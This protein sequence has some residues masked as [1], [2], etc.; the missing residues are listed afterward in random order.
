MKRELSPASR[1]L[2]FALAVAI[3]AV[4]LALLFVLDPSP[5]HAHRARPAAPAPPAVV[6]GSPSPLSAA[7]P[8]PAPAAV[9]AGRRFLRLYARV[10]SQPLGSSAARELRSLSSL[11]LARTLL[12]Q[13]PLPAGGARSGAALVA[14]RPERLSS[15]GVL[16][17]AAVR[18]AGSLVRVR[19]LLQRD[20]KRW[21]VTALL[22]AP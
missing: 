17:H 20:K 19:C 16:L 8:P 14:V 2:L 4:A 10:Q 15:S 9:A 1:L 22:S 21:T 7:E 6:Y 5:H 3:A 13:P 11:A 12:A 18:N